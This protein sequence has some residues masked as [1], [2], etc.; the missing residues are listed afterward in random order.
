MICRAC[1]KR[2]DPEEGLDC[3]RCGETNIGAKSGTVKSSMILISAHGKDAVYGSVREVP[4]PLRRKLL[5]STN[6]MNSATIVIADRKGR[7]EITRAIQNLPP[8]L[9]RR[10]LRPDPPAIAEWLARPTVKNAIACAL[11]AGSMALVWFMFAHK[12]F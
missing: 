11:G 5:Q 3:P 8:S 7:E 1:G 12:W 2:F 10:F 9:Q 6:G 4:Q